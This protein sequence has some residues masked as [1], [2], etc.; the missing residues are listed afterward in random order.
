MILGLTELRILTF[1]LL[2]TE[3]I[4]HLLLYG[5]HDLRHTFAVHSLEQ[6]IDHGLDPYCSLPTLSTYMGHRGVESTEYY[7]RLTKHYFINVLHYTQAQA[8]IIFPEV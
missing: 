2:F 3:N 5:T 7:L 6:S 4:I 1:S 8:D